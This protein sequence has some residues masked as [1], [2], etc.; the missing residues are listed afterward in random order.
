[1]KAQQGESARARTLKLNGSGNRK[2]EETTRSS[3]QPRILG[4][5][6]DGS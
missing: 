1:V 2:L 4:S 5:A 6:E 3:T